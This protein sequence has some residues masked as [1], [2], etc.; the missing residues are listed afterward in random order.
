MKSTTI[1]SFIGL[2][3][4]SVFTSASL[5]AQDSTIIQSDRHHEV[6]VDLSPLI[7]GLVA[8]AGFSNSGYEFSLMY[9]YHY[10]RWAI[11]GGLGGAVIIDESIINDTITDKRDNSHFRVR[12][13]IERKVNF[14]RR[15][16]IFYGTDLYYSYLISQD[17]TTFGNSRS[18][19]LY[20]I[21]DYYG[22]SPLV[23]FRFKL[24]KLISLTTE[25]SFLIY[26]YKS[27]Y[28][29][30]FTP[31]INQNELSSFE[32]WQSRFTPP[33]MLVLTLNF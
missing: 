5:K 11:R 17:E 26:Y 3:L 8:G 31:D 32:G 13:G 21:T 10:D 16:Q 15:W 19:R 27:D 2:A 12:L 22:I 25:T 29:R 7:K 33:T 28:D 30:V 14:E 1:I 24:N 6:G 9:R 23:G 18:S 4:V 20:G